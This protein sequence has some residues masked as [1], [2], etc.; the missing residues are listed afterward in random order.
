MIYVDF[1][2]T[3]YLHEKHWSYEDD[4][5]Y[6]F[7]YGLGIYGYK[8]SNINSGL[9]RA[10]EELVKNNDEP[11]YRVYVFMITGSRINLYFEAK[12]DFI[13]NNCDDIF[14]N[15]FSVSSQEEK[16]ELIKRYNEMFEIEH[17]IKVDKTIVIDDEYKVLSKC[18]NKNIIGMT[19][20]YFEK[21]YVNGNKEQ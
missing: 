3:L 11:F 10:I 20:L 9:I 8:K 4:L 7:R 5:D 2:D 17:G 6:N 21:Q 18:D 15:F 19:P 16:I 13:K 1:D 12:R 14:D